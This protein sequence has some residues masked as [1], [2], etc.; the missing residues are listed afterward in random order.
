MINHPLIRPYFLGGVSGIEG[1]P[2]DS[3]GK[4]GVSWKVPLRVGS[5]LPTLAPTSVP[6]QKV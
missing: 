4:K 5:L 6:N 3:Y 2:L 1:L